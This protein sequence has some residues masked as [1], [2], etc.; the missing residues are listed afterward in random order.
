M[1]F[2]PK[3]LYKL[4]KFC[5]FHKRKFSKLALKIQ[6]SF[7]NEA[8]AVLWPQLAHL[9]LFSIWS[10]QKDLRGDGISGGFKA[11]PNVGN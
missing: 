1:P 11:C 2:L 7:V 9:L 4:A 5:V 6:V 10:R 8:P 3:I